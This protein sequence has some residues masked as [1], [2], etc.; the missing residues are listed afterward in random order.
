MS[1][2]KVCM[3]THLQLQPVFFT[4]AECSKSNHQYFSSNLVAQITNK[5]IAVCRGT[6]KELPKHNFSLAG[7]IL[8]I[9]DL[10][11]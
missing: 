11:S 1:F 7:Q 2:Y 9:Q 6:K 5:H 8:I 3:S 10:F 4:E